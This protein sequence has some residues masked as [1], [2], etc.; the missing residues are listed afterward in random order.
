MTTDDVTQRSKGLQSAIVIVLW[1]ITAALGMWDI[2]LVRMMVLRT[3]LRF[4]PSG[5]AFSLIN[6]LVMIPLAITWVAIAI[7]GA[8]YHR[9]RV[10]RPDSWRMFSRTLAL[11]LSILLLPLFV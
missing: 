6:T 3:Y 9:A 1:L 7:G 10:G 2:L 4:V 11:E 5:E 8:E